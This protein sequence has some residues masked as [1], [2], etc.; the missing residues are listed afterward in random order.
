MHP[1][2]PQLEKRMVS[3]RETILWDMKMKIRI[4]KNNL[5]ALKCNL[6]RYSLAELGITGL[7]KKAGLQPVA[8]TKQRP[9]PKVASPKKKRDRLEEEVP[10][11]R[12]SRRRGGDKEEAA[13]EAPS[14]DALEAIERRSA[15]ATPRS[16]RAPSGRSMEERVHELEEVNPAISQL[17]VGS[18]ARLTGFKP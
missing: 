8:A 5:C 4:Q 11:R 18:W 6:C 15:L 14:L 12:S 7:A 1:V 9:A 3:T 17:V 13:L 16:P 10:T 2:H